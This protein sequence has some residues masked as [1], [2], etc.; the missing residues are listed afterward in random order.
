MNQKDFG[1]ITVL[2]IVVC[3]LIVGGVWYYQ[4][5]QS[6]S[7]QSTSS[8]T[9]APDLAG[10]TTTTSTPIADSSLSSYQS[11]LLGVAFSYPRYLGTIN[12]ATG[13]DL[14]LHT[15]DFIS[16]GNSA[17]SYLNMSFWPVNS[18]TDFN[19]PSGGNLYRYTGGAI[20]D[21]C[22]I[23]NY[24]DATDY[25]IQLSYCDVRT[26]PSGVKLAEFGGHYTPLSSIRGD[27]EPS[28]FE[29]AFM[30]TRSA[31]WPGLIIYTDDN[32]DYQN[33]AR[34]AAGLKSILNSLSYVKSS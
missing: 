23:V 20:D 32:D 29:G 30:Q 3:I 28:Q 11:R 16:F 6:A 5:D 13:T 24:F 31:R 1:P 4:T 34:D 26:L 27:A 33:Y 8:S 15:Q 22:S 14:N 7:L 9:S 18:S 21:A 19:I 2:L 25:S 17:S 12:E 10:T